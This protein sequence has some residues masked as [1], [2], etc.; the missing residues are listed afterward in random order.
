MKILKRLAASLTVV[1]LAF[2]LTA[3]NTSWVAK[4]GE[5][6][7]SSGVYLFYL[8]NAYLNAQQ[9]VSQSQTGATTDIFAQK[10][11]DKEARQWMID[12]ALDD[13]QIHAA[14]NK[15]FAELNL[16]LDDTDKETIESQAESFWETNSS[17][18]E[19]NGIGKASYQEIYTNTVKQQKIFY[20][21]YDKGGANEVKQADINDYF[22]KNY[23]RVKVASIPLVNTS[24]GEELPASDLQKAKAKLDD[25]LKRYNKGEKADKLIV[26]YNKAQITESG[27]DPTLSTD[28]VEETALSKTT[29]GFDSAFYDAIEKT[30]NGKALCTEGTIQNMKGYFFIEKL[31][32]K[33][34]A[35]LVEQNRESILAEMKSDEFE[36][37]IE[38]WG[39]DLKPE[40][41]NAAVNRYKP[42]K[43]K[44]A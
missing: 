32:I 12:Q 37:T 1:A 25:L 21:L 41:N 16:T 39:K 27:G 5:D 42:E 29:S 10:I 7:V 18:L 20:K 26:E 14:I 38:Q 6:T 34:N 8:L 24:T 43:L 35:T 9:Q 28:K 3:C 44:T 13:C 2:S 4:S 19:L 31:D 11:E 40:F 17:I 23:Y 15:K 33:G 22:Y 36:K 30:A